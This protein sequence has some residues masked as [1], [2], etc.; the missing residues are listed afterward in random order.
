MRLTFYLADGAEVLVDEDEH[1]GFLER[2]AIP[3]F[4]LDDAPNRPVALGAA[5]RRLAPLCTNRS[6]SH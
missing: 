5:R 6:K 3:K 4:S 2:E 1:L